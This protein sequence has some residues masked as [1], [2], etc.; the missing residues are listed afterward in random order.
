MARA[1]GEE[2][3]C[4]PHFLKHTLF[5][6]DDVWEVGIRHSQRAK[7]AIRVIN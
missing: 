4:V 5:L 2:N 6:K 3:L 1:P 7:K